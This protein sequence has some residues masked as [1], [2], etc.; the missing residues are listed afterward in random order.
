VALDIGSL[1]LAGALAAVIASG[2]M[3]TGNRIAHRIEGAGPLTL[4]L[5]LFGFALVLFGLHAQIGDLLAFGLGNPLLAASGL[6]FR[7]AVDRIRESPPGRAPLFAAGLIVL[8]EWASLTPR[9]PIEL[10]A[11]V[12]AVGSA[13]ALLLPL[14]ALLAGQGRAIGR[15]EIIAA[16]GLLI[17]VA[18]SL[19]RAISVWIDPGSVPFSA[20]SAANAAFAL[21]SLGIV[22]AVAVAILVMLR[23]HQRAQEQMHDALTGVFNRRAFLEQAKRVLSLGQ[24]REL[25]CSA[26]LVN[27]DRFGRVNESHG[28]RSGD[29]VLRHV[30]QKARGVLR[31]E[32]LL[33]RTAGAE[34]GLLLFATPASGAQALARRLATTLAAH[35]ARIRGVGIPVTA[36]VGIAEWKPGAPLDALELLERADRAVRQAKARGRDTIVGYDELPAQ[37]TA[38]AASA[39]VSGAAS[40]RAEQGGIR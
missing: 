13:I 38:S 40:D 22:A 30:A 3:Y 10:A 35:P 34:F 15:A 28:V 37:Q 2:A 23:E 32:D 12:G 7:L 5:L 9:S 11:T 16:C 21:A 19:V 1:Y 14:P 36:S 26:L 33:G 39:A 8:V 31:P 18:T 20:L 24:R 27:L 17:A 4:G 29:E 6:A 25:A